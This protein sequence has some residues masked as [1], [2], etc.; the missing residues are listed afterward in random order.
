MN[1][2]KSLLMVFVLGV[3]IACQSGSQKPETV[4]PTVKEPVASQPSTAPSTPPV[5]TSTAPSAGDSAV[6]AKINGQPITDA[7]ITERVKD[8][9]AKVETQI[10]EIKKAGLDDMIEEKLLEAQAAAKKMSVDDLLEKEVEKKVEQPTESEIDAF[11]G[12][13]KKRLKNKPLSEVKDQLVK[14]IKDNKK[15]SLYSKYIA[16]LKKGAKVE[17]L[18][19]RPRAQV[20]V[21]DDP[22]QGNPKAPITIIEFS[23][24]QCPFCKKT[25]PTIQQIMDTYKGKVHYVFRDF[26]LSFHKQARKASEAANCSNE[27]GKYWEYNSKLWENQGDLEPEKLKEYAKAL[28]LN[29]K[30]FVSCLDSGKYAEEID[31][32]IAD[33]SK[34]GVSGTPAYFINGIFVSGAQPFDKFQEIID[35]ELA[36]Q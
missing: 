15:S 6:L 12:I 30:K 35:E 8:R 3:F 19:T 4:K 1:F 22:S 36:G 13:Y 27:Q 28:G 29:E 10:Y 7:E 5:D 23:D 11:Y 16:Q 21:D 26:P 20:S 24:F 34:A 2:A 17:V 32:D 31:K 33:G 25:R 9:L 14:Q 18:M